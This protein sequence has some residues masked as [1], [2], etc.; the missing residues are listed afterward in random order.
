MSAFGHAGFGSR[1]R[2]NQLRAQGQVSTDPHG[3]G[4]RNALQAP[5]MSAYQAGPNPNARTGF[6]GPGRSTA[7][8]SNAYAAPVNMGAQSPA[9]PSNTASSGHSDANKY[10]ASGRI[11]HKS[12]MPV[13]WGREQEIRRIL[14]ERG[15][16]QKAAF[17]E[18]G[19][20]D[21]MADLMVKRD[22][23][24]GDD[25]RFNEALM[26]TMSYDDNT[27]GQWLKLMQG[28]NSA[29]A[30]NSGKLRT[31]QQIKA[32]QN[33]G[34]G[35]A[36]PMPTMG[37]AQPVYPTGPGEK[38]APAG[39]YDSYYL[40]QRQG[41]DPNS[42]Q[43]QQ[44]RQD[45]LNVAMEKGVGKKPRSG[46]LDIA[47]RAAGAGAG[48]GVSPQDMLRQQDE[49][50]R[51]AYVDE[52]TMGRDATDVGGY[53]ITH[54]TWQ[55]KGERRAERDS[56]YFRTGLS[57]AMLRPDQKGYQ[58]RVGQYAASINN[59]EFANMQRQLQLQA[60][61]QLRARDPVAYW[62][63]TYGPGWESQ[64]QTFAGDY[65]ANTEAGRNNQT[66]VRKAREAMADPRVQEALESKRK[67]DLRRL[68]L[69]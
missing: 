55:Q 52:Y 28:R 65:W 36:Q 5:D 9:R 16:S 61:E 49:R 62:Q 32:L 31:D 19:Y 25:A 4:V 2:Q 23:G 21:E 42:E 57:E 30:L 20:S 24:I 29:A 66:V 58:E 47:T 10:D 15:R 26:Q 68:G 13:Q 41:S 1:N 7:S 38:R 60:D 6:A 12:G 56:D 17:L 45:M 54:A 3:Q 59:K 11:T 64:V 53:D 33:S 43:G 44:Y 46:G 34:G 37:Q 63:Q 14:D 22:Y 51:A 48:G 69:A 40:G 18:Q 8:P 67:A 50:L 27:Y 35:A 39:N